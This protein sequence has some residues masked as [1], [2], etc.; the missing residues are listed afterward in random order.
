MK[1][2]GESVEIDVPEID[3]PSEE[4]I[5][6]MEAPLDINGGTHGWFEST[7]EEKERLHYRVFLPS[8]D[9]PAAPEAIVIFQHGLQSH[10]G[11]AYILSDGRKT[12]VALLTHEYQTSGFAVYSPDLIG[13][14]YSEGGRHVLPSNDILVQDL[15]KFVKLAASFHKSGTPIFLAG[16]SLGGNLAL[17]VAKYIQENPDFLPNFEGLILFSPAIYPNTIYAPVRYILEFGLVPIFGDRR[18]PSWVPNPIAPE[19]I[20]RDPE[21]LEI[22]KKK[23]GIMG[24]GRHPPYKTLLTL[25]N[26]M[27]KVRDETIPGLTVPFCLVHGAKDLAIPVAGAEFLVRTV[28]TPPADFA[29]GRYEEA[30]HDLLGEPEAPEVMKFTQDWIEKRLANSV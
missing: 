21:R 24:A 27:V 1:V 7:N 5:R 14:G 15:L 16:E 2:F 8:T 26:A 17:Q 19:R 29:Y 6:E 20:W 9:P 22:G 30:L 13:H 10:S 3:F 25:T 28:S 18:L 12:N 23:D 4:V 11:M